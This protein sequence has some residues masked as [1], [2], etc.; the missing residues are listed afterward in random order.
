M[1]ICIE[2][3]LPKA[4]QTVRPRAMSLYQVVQLLFPLQNITQPFVI[5]F[6]FFLL[7]NKACSKYRAVLK[8][9][10]QSTSNPLDQPQACGPLYGFLD[11]GKKFR[12]HP[13]YDRLC[14]QHRKDLKL[15]PKSKRPS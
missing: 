11:N 4:P 14:L 15:N 9:K 7:F 3:Q 12:L 10:N 5:L 6:M 8:K 2:E 1:Q 13:L